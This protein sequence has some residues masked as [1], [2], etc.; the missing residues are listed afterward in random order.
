MPEPIL[1]LREVT[2][3]FRAGT[4]D[5]ALA[6]DRV[7]L[8]LDEGEFVVVVGTNGSGKS[9]LLAV[10]SG[11]LTPT[12]GR[13]WLRSADVTHQRPHRRARL[14][15][16]VVQNP[17]AGTAPHLTV[18]ENLALAEQR[19]AAPSV[20]RLMGRAVDARAR[21][22]FA[23]RLEELGMG[24]EARL[25]AP[26]GAL[27]GGQ[28]QAV[29][30]L[31]ATLARPVVL[32]LDEHTAALDPRSADRVDA[33]TRTIVAREGLTTL[34]VTHSMP[35]AVRQGTR[36]VM[37]HRGRIAREFAGPRRRRLHVQDLLDCFEQLRSADLLDAS[38]AEMLRGQYV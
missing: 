6:L 23:E 12:R 33:L 15:S 3:A 29:T 18:A 31:M 2:H 25:D 28:R 37:L 8:T 4:P 27:S 30:L 9:T 35:Q 17:L 1:A 36:V 10:V 11:A 38:A 32:L 5:E 7:V 24:L 26:I 22:R 13:V 21:R 20:V 16:T 19:A 34:M 14:V